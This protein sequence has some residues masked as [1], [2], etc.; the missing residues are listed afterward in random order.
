M[1][2][3]AKQQIP[4]ATWWYGSNQY[5]LKIS[6]LEPEWLSATAAMW[7]AKPRPKMLVFS[8][9][10]AAKYFLFRHAA[11]IKL[12]VK[13]LQTFGR[14]GKEFQVDSKVQILELT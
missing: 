13:A 14:E 11:V 3:H 2:L 5:H 6:Q 8:S 10:R 1:L 9:P 4:L 7:P 12:I